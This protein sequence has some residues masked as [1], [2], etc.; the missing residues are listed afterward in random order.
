MNCAAPSLAAILFSAA[1]QTAV[2]PVAGP[3]PFWR[4]QLAWVALVPWFVVLLRVSK[5]ANRPVRNATLL[6]YLCGALWYMGHCYWIFQT[7][8]QYG[9]MSSFM[10]AVV[11]VLFCLYLG[12]YHALFGFLAA[13]L[14]RTNS[15]PIRRAAPVLLATLWVGVELA[16]AHVTSFPWDLLGYSQVDNAALARLAPWAGTYAIS[17]LVVLVN[18][19]IACGLVSRFR[20]GFRNP[21]QRGRAALISG[22]TA[23]LVCTLLG[24]TIHAPMPA[25]DATAV[26]VQPN[27]AAGQ[28]ERLDG[29]ATPLEQQLARLSEQTI[30]AAQ[31]QDRT[32]H[33]ILWPEA[34]ASYEVHE[35]AFQATLTNLARNQNSTVIADSNAVDPNSSVARRYNLYNSAALFTAEGLRARYDKIHLVPFGEF[36][37]YAELFSFA[38]GLTQQVGLFDR[39]HLRTPLSDG[40]HHYGTF[41]CYESIFPDEV[42]QLV[43]KG[44]DVLVNLSD[45]GWY[46]DTSAPFQHIN[47]ARMRAIENRRW[48][49]R[50]TNNGITASIDPYGTVRQSAPRHQRLAAVMQYGYSRQLTFYTRHGD[51]F[52]Y[53]C[54]FLSLIALVLAL[55]SPPSAGAAVN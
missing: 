38:S 54:A 39:G 41:I 42:R 55:T 2:F 5:S 12:L 53:A 51:L 9:N 19:C 35:P 11:L 32:P 22:V 21:S 17:F 30:Q 43:L 25:P 15:Q 34:P 33:L 7:M 46:G 3:L 13:V 24:I 8:H 6:S 10:A 27:L 28:E 47:M 23:A 29:P 4:A 1:L 50:D 18:A 31:S 40:T 14:L 37:P 45:D 26:L 48:L 44:A 36:T 20:S 52:A 16:R 49:L